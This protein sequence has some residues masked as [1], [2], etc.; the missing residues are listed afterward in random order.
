MPFYE[1]Q[2]YITP[3]Y[4]LLLEVMRGDIR[5]PRF[6]RPGTEIVWTPEQRGD[7]LDSL[8]RGFPVGTILLWSTTTP[9]PCLDRVAG[10]PVVDTSSRTTMRLLLD[11][12]QRL[13]TLL[14]VLGPGLRRELPEQPEEPDNVLKER[15]VFET[16]RESDSAE[17]REQFLA[18]KE[19]VAPSSTQVPLDIVLDRLEMN[20]WIRDHTDLTDEQVRSAESVRDKL[21]E[22]NIPVA[23][24]AAESLEDATESFK[25]VNS[26]GTPM[27]RFHMVKALAYREDFDLEE[28]F[29]ELKQEHLEP[30]GWGDIDNTDILRVCAGLT[31]DIPPTKINIKKLS[32][33]LRDDEDLSR[34]AVEACAGAATAVSHVGIHGPKALP[35]SWQLITLAVILGQRP[36]SELTD[37][38]MK[39]VREWFWVTTYGEV[40]AG[41]TATYDRAR[42]SLLQTMQGQ[43]WR[44][45]QME[46][47]VTR[48]VEEVKRFDFRAVRSKAFGLLLARIYDDGDTSGPAHRALA[49]R[50]AEALSTLRSRSPR[51]TWSA[52]VITTE[53]EELRHVRDLMKT[54][55][56]GLAL[57]SHVVTG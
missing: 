6:Q 29:V 13:S 53:P 57:P 38:E 19:G 37:A 17:T 25:R 20:R 52:L 16:K 4:Q 21:R 44:D 56:R 24:L 3:L 32:A 1:R 31:T 40:F 36:S 26:S 35:Y 39:A 5:V 10:F 9:I 8:F 55:Q 18:L 30:I 48:Y 11:G 23:V 49:V 41:V 34:K 2:P 45:T 27:G 33:R 46:R 12:H 54:P 51:S 47:D 14:A 43:R 15:W 7:L 22:Y 28:R 42:K 50:G